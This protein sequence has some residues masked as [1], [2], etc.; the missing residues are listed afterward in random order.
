MPLEWVATLRMT[1]VSCSPVCL[2]KAECSYQPGRGRKKQLPK[3]GSKAGCRLLLFDLSEASVG[4]QLGQRDFP[5]SG[6]IHQNHE[7]YITLPLPSAPKS[8]DNDEVGRRRLD[9]NPPEICLRNLKLEAYAKGQAKPLISALVKVL[10][11]VSI[12]GHAWVNCV[13]QPSA[14]GKTASY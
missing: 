11:V 7:D 2:Q 8:E 14:I 12:C 3:T 6:N 13:V 10:H 9:A 5:L 1:S 4:Q